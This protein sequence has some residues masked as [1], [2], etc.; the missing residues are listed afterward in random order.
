M[1]AESCNKSCQTVL[2]ADFVATCLLTVL[3]Q[4]VFIVFKQ[5]CSTVFAKCNCLSLEKCGLPVFHLKWFLSV[6]GM[7]LVWCAWEHPSGFPGLQRREFKA[8]LQSS[9]PVWFCFV[10]HIAPISWLSWIPSNSGIFLKFSWNFFF[11]GNEG[12]CNIFLSICT[13]K[14]YL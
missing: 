4:I 9:L 8:A 11:P 1:K 12:L 13:L 14:N 2:T 10:L 6:N 3:W 7:I 5:F